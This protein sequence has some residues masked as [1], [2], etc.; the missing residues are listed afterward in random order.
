MSTVAARLER[1][2]FSRFHLKLLIM[3]GLGFT[4]E[5]ADAGLIAFILPVIRAKW[6]LTSFETG[7]IGSSTYIGFLFGALF[8]GMLGDRF[9]RKVVMSTALVTFCLMTLCNA[10]VNDWH[11]FFVFRMLAGVGMGAEGAIIAP[12]LS[13]FVSRRYRGTFTGALAGFFSFGFVLS[14]IVGY[15]LI[16]SYSDGWRYAMVLAASPVLLLLWWRRS[17]LESPRWLEYRGRVDEALA[18]VTRIEQQIERRGVV[19]PPVDLKAV[20]DQRDTKPLGL[21]EVLK[22][23]WTPPLASTTA[24]IWVFWISITFCA[25]AFLT[26]IPGLLVQSG[27]TMT[28]SFSYTIAIYLAQIPGYYCGAFCNEQLGRKRSIVSF[29]LLACLAAIWLSTAKD[30]HTMLFASIALSFAMNGVVSGQ[31]AYTPEVFPT[32]VRATGMGAASAF[33]RIGAIASPMLVGYIF[34]LFGFAGVFGMTTAVLAIGGLVVLIFGKET[35]GLSLET[36]AS[37]EYAPVM[38]LPPQIDSRR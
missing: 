6:Q 8:A 10:F 1:L 7:M 13:E 32:E 2:P 28:K 9:G 21:T 22:V 24:M 31:Y 25:Y 37:E 5:A 3:G 16:P 11:T 18:I 33:G 14:A 15:F 17:L 27:L 29:M 30:A 4:F 35:R 12:F 19:L 23:L 20:V 38:S 34:P 26:W 36:I